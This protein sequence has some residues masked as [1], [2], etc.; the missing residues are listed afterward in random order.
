M[1]RTFDEW[2]KDAP[3]MT[4][5]K[6]LDMM[7]ND[8]DE[9]RELIKQHWRHAWKDDM[10]LNGDK[11]EYQMDRADKAEM[12]LASLCDAI[13]IEARECGSMEADR[14][15]RDEM[16]IVVQQIVDKLRANERK[17]KA[18]ADQLIEALELMINTLRECHAL[19]R[20]HATPRKKGCK[21]CD[22]LEQARAVLS[23]VRGKL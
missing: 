3:Q 12:E 21:Y 14:P 15:T 19:N 17:A 8:W 13:N 16:K 6:L 10:K 18:A 1:T 4:L 5:R 11:I 2:G 22:A 23:S 20:R 9:D 7:Y